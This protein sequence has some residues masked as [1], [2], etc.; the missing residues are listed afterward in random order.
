L[1]A[2]FLTLQFVLTLPKFVN[3]RE[4]ELQKTIDHSA[5]E[6]NGLSRERLHLAV[7]LAKRGEFFH[8]LAESA[9]HLFVGKESTES[10][11]GAQLAL[12]VESFPSVVGGGIFY[13]PFAFQPK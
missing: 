1:G 12:L 11:I 6:L 4:T 13:E 2:T 7:N 10:L 8:S 5:V 9:Q 3:L